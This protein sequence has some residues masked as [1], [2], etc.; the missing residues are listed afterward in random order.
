[1]YTFGGFSNES[2]PANFDTTLPLPFE[3]TQNTIWQINIK[4]ASEI[5]VNNI[6]S[7][8]FNPI[9]K[10]VKF[11]PIGFFIERGDIIFPPQG[12][13]SLYLEDGIF[14]TFIPPIGNT[15]SA[16]FFFSITGIDS[17]PTAN[18]NFTFSFRSTGSWNFFIESV[19][20]F[21]TRIPIGSTN[22]S[23][24]FINYFF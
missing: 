10:P 14:A 2:Y 11:L 3:Q 18:W 4:N 23:V 1:L 5:V 6:Q 12:L 19:D 21:K 9:P 7:P 13:T 22:T 15:F 8:N 20:Q 16:L 24:L 17:D